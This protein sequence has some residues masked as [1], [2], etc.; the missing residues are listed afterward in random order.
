[1]QMGPEVHNILNIWGV[2][3]K[4]IPKRASRCGVWWKRLIGLTKE[5]LKEDLG[6]SYVNFQTWCTVVT[7]IEAVHNDR[8]LAKVISNISDPEPLTQS[9]LIYGRRFT[10]LHC[11]DTSNAD[12]TS[13]DMSN[14][15]LITKQ[16]RL[17]RKLIDDFNQRWWREYLAGLRQHH[18]ATGNN[19]QKIF[20]WDV[21]Q[22]HDDSSRA[23]WNLAVVNNLFLEM[24]DAFDQRLSRPEMVLPTDKLYP[25]EVQK[26][27]L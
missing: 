26:E 22:I 17:Q 23:L 16:A 25:L 10:S 20:V 3:W 2:D 24:T 12:V 4:F 1:M 7:E 6:R 19:M 21:V 13:G 27:N 14:Y 9:H 15:Q 18:Q 5:T 11:Q 8:P